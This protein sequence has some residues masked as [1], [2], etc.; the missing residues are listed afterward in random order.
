MLDYLRGE[1]EIKMKVS[2]KEDKRLKFSKNIMFDI[3]EED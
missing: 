1:K 3:V 2:E